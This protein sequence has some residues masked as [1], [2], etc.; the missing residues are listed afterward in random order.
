MLVQRV[1][2]T[3]TDERRTMAELQWIKTL[4][5]LIL[6]LQFPGENIREF[7]D[8]L[9]TAEEEEDDEE[10]ITNCCILSHSDVICLICH[11][12][13][14]SIWKICVYHCQGRR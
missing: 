5:F 3:E 8:A 2:L 9:E 13:S 1:E 14:K 11:V 6:M 4:L 12:L 10:V 7:T